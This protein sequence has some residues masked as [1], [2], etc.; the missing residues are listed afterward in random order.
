MLEEWRGAGK[1]CVP[2]AI[3]S[4]PEFGSVW[5]TGRF[6][7]RRMSSHTVSVTAWED[8]RHPS[9]RGVFGAWSLN[10]CYCWQESWDENISTKTVHTI[11]KIP[12]YCN[13]TH[14][15]WMSVC[16]FFFFPLFFFCF[17]SLVYLCP[18]HL[19]SKLLQDL[20]HL[21][22]SSR[23]TQSSLINWIRMS[24]ECTASAKIN[25]ALYDFNNM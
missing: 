17:C 6:I 1:G 14:F 21:T 25:Y 20:F 11:N 22:N 2:L 23:W 13:F 4:E 16:F 7:C 12:V 8:D 10:L 24:S 15:D 5:N 19:F 9:R 3:K 18:S